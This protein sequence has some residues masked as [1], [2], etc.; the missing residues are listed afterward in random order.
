MRSRWDAICVVPS[1]NTDRLHPLQVIA[2]YSIEYDSR[3][4]APLCR[5]PVQLGHGRPHRFGYVTETRFDGQRILILDDVYTT[6]A[7]SQSAA[8]AL[9]RAG[10][11][12]A[13]VAVIGRR[14]NPGAT[15]ELTEWSRRHGLATYPTDT[16]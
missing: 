9:S 4:I 2:D 13:L 7:R 16:N 12:I 5:G 15:P 11:T 14:I 6:G 3:L 10:A 8:H 1:S